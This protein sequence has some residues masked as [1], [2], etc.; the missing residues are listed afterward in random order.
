MFRS[1]QTPPAVHHADV[2]SLLW[3]YRT[4][5]GLSRAI[6]RLRDSQR[7]SQKGRTTVTSAEIWLNK[8]KAQRATM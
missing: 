7:G 2:L 4:L 5:L 3:P 1:T 6:S 8:V